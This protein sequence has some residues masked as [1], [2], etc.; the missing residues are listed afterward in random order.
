MTL[1]L[2]RVYAAVGTFV[3]TKFYEAKCSGS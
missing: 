3:C 2:N 1:T